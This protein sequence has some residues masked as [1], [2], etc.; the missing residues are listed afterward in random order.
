ML[1][2]L[3]ERHCLDREQIDTYKYIRAI[4]LLIEANKHRVANAKL[5]RHAKSQVIKSLS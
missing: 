1:A 3:S 2:V 4:D 5:V